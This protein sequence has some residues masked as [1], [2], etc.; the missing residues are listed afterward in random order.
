V[1]TVV[2]AFKRPGYFV[3]DDTKQDAV[4]PRPRAFHDNH[5][6]SRAMR[7]FWQQGYARTSVRDLEQA[8]GLTASSL[9]NAYGNKEALF[10]QVLD[11]YVE[12]I[13]QRRIDTYLKNGDPIT[14]IRRFF[15][16]TFDYLDDETA[17]LACLLTNTAQELGQHSE[18]V[19]ARLKAGMERVEA[20]FR[21]ALSRRPDA[22][23]AGRQIS[24]LA[25]SLAAGLQGLL[26]TSRVTP[27]PARLQR[28]T[29]AILAPLEHKQVS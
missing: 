3:S 5:T 10:E 8:T 17:P 13:V 9:Y 2:D 25:A 27:E 18:A 15:E 1:A 22:L 26:V 21:D 16:T 24:Q 28:L 29:D 7:V 12:G 23:P 4:M 20:A 6:L 11:H 19:H 14:G